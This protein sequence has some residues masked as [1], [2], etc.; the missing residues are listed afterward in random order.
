MPNHKLPPT[1]PRPNPMDTMPDA[2]WKE[3]DLVMFKS[4]C[5]TGVGGMRVEAVD[6]N[7][8]DSRVKVDGKWWASGCFISFEAWKAQC[9]QPCH[10]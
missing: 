7:M 1:R 9:A 8:F 2:P 10:R 3:G 4:R 5:Q 6:T